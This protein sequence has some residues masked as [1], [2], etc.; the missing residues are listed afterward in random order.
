MIAVPDRIGLLDRKLNV[1][2]EQFHDYNMWMFWQLAPTNRHT[3]MSGKETT[4][5]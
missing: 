3:A 1:L 5:F 4:S 2:A